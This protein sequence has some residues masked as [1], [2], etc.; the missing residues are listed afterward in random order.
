MSEKGQVGT[1]KARRLGRVFGP[2]MGPSWM[3][4]H[5][6]YPTPIL[7]DASRIRVFFNTRDA[8]NRGSIGWVDV[9]V[10]NPLTILEVSKHPALQPGPLGCFD[11]RGVSN[12]N[13]LRINDHL[14][15]YYLGWNKSA[16]VP[17]RNAIG[18]AQCGARSSSSFER[19]FEGPLL[20]RSRWD[21]FTLSYPF[22]VAGEAGR[23]WRMF[24]GTSRGG[25]L[26]EDDMRHAITVAVSDDGVD[27]RPI[28]KNVLELGAG[29]FGLSRP[30]VVNSQ[31]GSHMLF[32]IRK[33][34]YAIGSATQSAATGDW[35][36]TSSDLLGPSSE[37]WDNE[38]TCY[39]AAIDVGTAHY[40]FYCGNG[41]GHTGFGVALLEGI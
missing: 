8:D 7:L 29:E 9:S 13:I 6:A 24:Y 16:D 11:D 34:R 32:S 4:S 5:A 35:L 20:D 28:G 36:R 26:R 41:Y 30:W 40:M 19:I 15:L 37:A 10:A 31:A 21:P 33:A 1:L 27:W 14:R 25:G 2:E 22:V 12:G 17:F 23:P 3:V 18:A 38:A 39:A